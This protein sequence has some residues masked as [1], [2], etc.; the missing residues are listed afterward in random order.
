MPPLWNDSPDF[1]SA[2]RAAAA[3][4]RLKRAVT[5]NTIRQYTGRRQRMSELPDAEA[6]KD[7]AGRI[8]QHALDNL[9][10]YLDQFCRAVVRNGGHV[11]LAATA[12][13]AREVILRIARESHCTRVIKS[14]S[15]VTEEIGLA[16]EMERAGMDVVETDLGEF[17]VQI[18][19]DRPSH[20]VGPI[21]HKDVE[22]ISRCFSEYFHV[23]CGTDPGELT[24]LARSHLRGKFRA[25]DMGMTGGNFLVAETGQV[26]VVENS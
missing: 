13:D 24:A 19:H 11:H 17:I 4:D 12:A 2:S 20:L 10:Y 26:C 22:S 3:N 16:A 5:L 21:I 15:M 14:K 23:S 18:S 25:S 1:K 6:L 8:R 9:D 7:L